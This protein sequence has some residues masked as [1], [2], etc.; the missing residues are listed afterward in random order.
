MDLQAIMEAISAY[1]VFFVPAITAAVEAAK[2]VGLPTKAAMALA[3][4]LGVVSGV[5]YVAPG[6]V[7]AGVL[8]GVMLGLASMG[9]YDVTKKTGQ[10]VQERGP[11]DGGDL[12][13]A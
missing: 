7:R 3:L 6:D 5:V 9:L 4:A 8:V 12:S 2:R 1:S 11:Q 13:D 10:A